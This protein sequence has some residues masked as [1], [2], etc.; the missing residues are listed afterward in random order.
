MSEPA[1]Q[2]PAGPAHSNKHKAGGPFD[3]DELD[4]LPLPDGCTALIRAWAG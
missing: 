1:A 3:L 4:S 2:S